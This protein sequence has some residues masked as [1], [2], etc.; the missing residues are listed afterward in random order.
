M[1]HVGKLAV[2]QVETPVQ[3]AGSPPVA[4]APE[5]FCSSSLIFLKNILSDREFL[6]DSGA[7]V[8]VLPGP[9]SLS[10]DGVRLL[11]AEGLPML[12]SGTCIIPLSFS[13]GSISKVYTLNFQLAPVSVPLLGADFLENFNLLVNIKGGKVVHAD[14]PEDVLIHT[15]PD[16]Q[17]H[18]NLCPIFQLRRR[19]RNFWK[20]FQMFYLPTDL[21]LLNLATESIIIYLLTLVHQGLL[22]L[23][24]YIQKN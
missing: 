24:V 5:E 13:W 2:W 21:L 12:C 16:P 23:D 14:C 1:F 18:S 4:S 17:Q 8:L 22:N 20:S 6:V 10:V 9:K 7:S 11:T 15:S 3:P 19:L